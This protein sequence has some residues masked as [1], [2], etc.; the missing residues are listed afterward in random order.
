[1]KDKGGSIVNVT[2]VHGSVAGRR[3]SAYCASKGGLEMLTKALA[4]DW[5]T[6]PI[7]V[8]ALAPGYFETE[9]TA[10]LRKSDKWREMLLSRTPLGRFGQPQELVQ[11]ALFLL[12]PASGYIT[13][14]SLTVDGGWTAA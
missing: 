10:A 12:S 11:A 8:N 1:M 4:L 2:S 5:A 6:I 13:G 9:M 3:L 14:S 7:R